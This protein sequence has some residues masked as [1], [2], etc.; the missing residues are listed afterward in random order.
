M[1]TIFENRKLYL[2]VKLQ[3]N[4]DNSNSREAGKTV[5]IIES[6]NYQEYELSNYPVRIIEGTNYQV[7]Q[8]EL[9]RVRISKI[10]G[11]NY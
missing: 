3:W 4:L 8:C 9:L 10:L 5:Q 7:I 1:S 6:T 11:V 2:R